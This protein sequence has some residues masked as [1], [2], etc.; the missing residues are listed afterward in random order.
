MIKR[1]I[2]SKII[3]TILIGIIIILFII[4]NI[5]NNSKRETTIIQ[6]DEKKMNIEFELV[7][8]EIIEIYEKSD[9]K[10]LGFK[11][12]LDD[13]IN[14]EDYVTI[15]SNVDTNIPG[16]YEITYTLKYED[17]L[18]VL[19]RKVIVNEIPLDDIVLTL[20]G[21]EIIYLESGNIYEDEGAKAYYNNED[22][23]EKI[24]VEKEEEE[25]N[26][27]IKYIIS[28][29]VDTK[30]IK[31]KIIYIDIDSMF[32]LDKDTLVL[33]I[34]L[35]DNIDHI[36]LPNNE[37][38][39]EKEIVYQIENSGI[40][41]YI[42]YTD[43]NKSFEKDIEIK[44]E[45]VKAPTGTCEAI[46]KAGETTV[47]VNTEDKVK[48]YIYNGVE[49][50]SDSYKIDKY[51]RD[52]N[53]KLIGLNNKESEIK[54]DVK[55]EYLPVI[56][57]GSGEVTKKT[58]ESDS[59]KVYINYK[60]GFW[61]TRVWVRDANYQLNKVF[62]VGKYLK[63]PKNILQ[64]NFKSSMK[65]KIV[66]AF[67]ASPPIMVGSY[68][69]ELAKSH[70][71]Y[72]LREPS[73]LLIQ[74]GKVIIRDSTKYITDSNIFYI[75]GSNQLTA[76][77]GDK[78]NNLKLKKPDERE[79]IYQEVIDSGARNTMVWWPVMVDNYKAKKLNSWEIGSSDYNAYR[80]GLCQVDTNNFIVITTKSYSGK[81]RRPKFAEFL[82]TLG[83]RYA[84]NF[85]GGGSYAAL[86]KN[87][88]TNS[89]SI[90]AGGERSL[91]SMMYFTEL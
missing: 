23:S 69:G 34:N 86:Y 54:C 28:N 33:K 35:D 65:N 20:N 12:I 29:S 11:A 61:V 45:D 21:D 39:S 56:K 41:K 8:D 1:I 43:N 42:L 53:V 89:I 36:Q 27:Y 67:N 25:N 75:N 64:D 52:S 83:C 2:D 9:Y 31:R 19:T 63:K 51:L 59:L 48:K 88:G 3:W 7:D 50:E 85:D 24:E 22:I 16:E 37:L 90:L 15:D 73:S 55:M 74:N 17:I 6:K 4:L 30:E 66:Y 13:R 71:E 58:M 40:Y 38:S 62:V 82:G 80:S 57:K 81:V 79:K 72:N 84:I 70:P 5:V 46:L 14:L 18:K 77:P 76:I 60:G 49:T 44:E 91:S 26:Y 32:N 87:K 68:Y 10:D 78:N 47:K